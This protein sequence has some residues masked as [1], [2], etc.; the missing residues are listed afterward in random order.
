MYTNARSGE[1]EATHARFSVN[2]KLLSLT[3]FFVLLFHSAFAYSTTLLVLVLT[4]IEE[5][6]IRALVMVMIW[7][8]IVFPHR[9]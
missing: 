8:S 3:F 6:F 1:V 2:F 5:F 7:I 9:L 4:F